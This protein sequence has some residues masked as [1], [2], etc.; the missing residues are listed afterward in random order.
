MAIAVSEPAPLQA[1]VQDIE[2][3]LIVDTLARLVCG[4]LAFENS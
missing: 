4:E 3:G 1:K 2:R